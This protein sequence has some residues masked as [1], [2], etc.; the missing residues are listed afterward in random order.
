MP[1]AVDPAVFGSLLRFHRQQQGLSLRGLAQRCGIVF[2]ALYDFEHSRRS[3]NEG[4][5]EAL[6]TAFALNA[7][8]RHA[9]FYAAAIAQLP[10]A[11]RAAVL[12]GP[13]KG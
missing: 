8:Q 10:P 12:N 11:F 13:R 4:H 7:G 6:C 3:P 1:T 9:M 2:S 5:V